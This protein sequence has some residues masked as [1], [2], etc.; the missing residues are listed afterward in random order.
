MHNNEQGKTTL[1]ELVME[2]EKVGT[3]R[4]ESKST[5][6]KLQLPASTPQPQH[7]QILIYKASFPLLHTRIYILSF[8]THLSGA[9][10]FSLRLIYCHIHPTI[11]VG[12]IA[13]PNHRQH[14]P[15]QGQEGRRRIRH[16]LPST[17][18]LYT[19]RTS[20]RPLPK[21]LSPNNPARTTTSSTSTACAPSTATSPGLCRTKAQAKATS[22]T[23]G[24]AIRPSQS[25]KQ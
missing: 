24:C 16:S 13:E 19:P 20:F 15:H 9:L 2:I 21:T 14:V 4:L 5:E 22:S 12:A 23:T 7:Q 1:E 11:S 10:F 6:V 17:R 8:L 18:T 25:A 3:W